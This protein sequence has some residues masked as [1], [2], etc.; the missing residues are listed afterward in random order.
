MEAQCIEKSEIESLAKE[1]LF[2]AFNLLKGL[3]CFIYVLEIFYVGCSLFSS[4]QS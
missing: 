3:F 1:F 2:L 4:C